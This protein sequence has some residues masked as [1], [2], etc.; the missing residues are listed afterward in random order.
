MV[1]MFNGMKD[2]QSIANRKTAT[3]NNNGIETKQSTKLKV[4]ALAV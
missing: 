3:M 1:G 2:R 4:E